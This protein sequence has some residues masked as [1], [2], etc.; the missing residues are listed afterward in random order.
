MI[1][2]FK[3]RIYPTPRQASKLLQTL[4]T[5][6]FLYNSA[7]SERI[8]KY[9]ESKE[10]ISYFQQANNLKQN[11]NKYQQ[12]VHSQV[13]QETLKRLD[14]SFSDFFRRV[15]NKESKVGFPRFKPENRFNS[16]CYPQAGFGISKD[17]KRIKLSKIGE[18][19]L[20][21]SR[22][23]ENIKTCRVIRESDQWF[24]VLTSKIENKKQTNFNDKEI[25]IDVGITNYLT[26]SDGKT[27]ENP[28]ILKSIEKKLAKSQRKL[29]KKQ[30]GSKNRNKQRLNVFRIHRKIKNTRNDF[31]HKLSTNLVKDY[32]KL[33]FED[34][35]IKGMLKNHKLAKHISDCSW[36]KLIEMTRYK[37]EEAGC[38]FILINARNTS[39]ICSNCNSIEKKTLG[40]RVHKC[41]SCGFQLDRDH[42]AAINI[43]NRAGTARINASG[44]SVRPSLNSKDSNEAMSLNEESPTNQA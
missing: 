27:I 16:F 37:A 28:R 33:V 9:K 35:N 15:K 25:G 11:K 22:E 30:K 41:S 17:K 18:I 19:K 31:L 23:V 3:Y 42:N 44:D 32:G 6:R 34:L 1:K 8:F 36:Y 13:L 29:S 24:I 38:E 20:K 5:C 14:K 2:S 12:K 7:L 26:F 43:L 10:S 39:Q 40:D 4:T 21:Y